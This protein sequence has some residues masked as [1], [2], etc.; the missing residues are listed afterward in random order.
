MTNKK[1]LK[2]LKDLY[3]NTTDKEVVLVKE[4]KAEAVKWAEYYR[5]E[6]NHFPI[7]YRRGCL[8]VLEVFF[9]LTE[10]ELK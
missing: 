8:E 9:N 6:N 1:K 7:A 3:E 4:L 2:T 10:V 5:D